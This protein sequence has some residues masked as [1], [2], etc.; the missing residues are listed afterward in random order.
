MV[1]LII[2]DDDLNYFNRP[3]DIERAY[4][5]MPDIPVSFACVPYVMDLSTRGACPETNGNKVPR[6]FGD[7][8]ALVNYI[9]KGIKEGRYDVLLHGYSHEYKFDSAGNRYPEMVWRESKESTRIIPEGKMYLEKLFDTSIHWFVAPSNTISKENLKVIYENNL[10]FSGIVRLRFNRELTF[11]SI[12]NYLKR[13]YYRYANKVN[14]P[15]VL[16]YGTHL[17]L[18]AEALHSLDQEVE[19]NHFVR[20]FEFC[21]KHNCP[22]AINVHCWDMRDHPEKYDAFFSFLQYAISKGAVPSTF[23]ELNNIM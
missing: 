19:Y 12:Q 20:L 17:E 23:R 16:N 18:N 6:P 13:L 22:M 21:K 5:R 2:R 11:R 1:Q 7:N 4:S 8:A 10:N 14:Y 9:K 15:G 3:E